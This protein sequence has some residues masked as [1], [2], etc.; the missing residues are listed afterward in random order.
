HQG[1]C[2]QA[3]RAIGALEALGEAP[4]IQGE[5]ALL[6]AGLAHLRGGRDAA[7]AHLDDADRHFLAAGMSTAQAVVMLRCGDLTQGAAGQV[8]RARG[9]QR[10]RSEGISEPDEWA[11]AFAPGFGE[12]ARLIRGPLAA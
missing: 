12:P 4:A 5:A 11:A 10:L 3:E 2:E 8:L 1:C 7:R 6:R 9:R